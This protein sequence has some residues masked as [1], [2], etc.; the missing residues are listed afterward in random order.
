[1]HTLWEERDDREY[2][3]FRGVMEYYKSTL[4]KGD[5]WEVRENADVFSEGHG[6]CRKS[7]RNFGRNISD[8]EVRKTA[9]LFTH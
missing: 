1:M 7:E 6:E 8:E 4:I 3:N 9:H 5:V 2:C